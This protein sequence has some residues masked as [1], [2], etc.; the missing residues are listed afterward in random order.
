MYV[1]PENR[2]FSHLSEGINGTNLCVDST[3]LLLHRGDKDESCEKLSVT[4]SQG[5]KEH[6]THNQTEEG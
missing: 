1:S 3:K 4:C 2:K 6:P 5:Q